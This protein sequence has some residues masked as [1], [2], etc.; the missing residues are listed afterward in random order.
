M[1]PPLSPTI[2]APATPA[3]QGALAVVRLSGPEALRIADACWRGKRLSET[4]SHTV[5]V[6]YLTDA[7]GKEIDQGVATVFKAPTSFTGEDTVEFSLHGSPWI[8]RSVVERLCE[9]G[10]TV[11]SGGE[12]TRRAFINGRL[13][14]AQAE[15][16]ADMIAASSKAAASLAVTQLKGDF[17]RALAGLRD[18]MIDI[19]S[20]LELELDFSEEDVEF[21][22]RRRL[23]ALVEETLGTVERLARS[24]HAGEV[25]K[26]GVPVVIAGAPN[27][28]KS[29]LLNRIVGEEK[30]IVTEIPGTTRDMIEATAEISGVLFRF[31]DTAGIRETADEIERIGI[32]RARQAM[33]RARIL[34]WLD[35]ADTPEQSA[36]CPDDTLPDAL[37]SSCIPI[38]LR[39][40]SDLAPQVFEGDD[41]STLHVSALTGEGIP[42]LLQ[43]LHTIATE[44]YNPDTELIITNR[45]HHDSLCA[46]SEALHRVADG[47]TAGL[48]ADLV[49]QDLREATHHL[50]LITGAVTPSDLLHTIFSRFCI[51]K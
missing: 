31:I 25:F 38:R 12:F 3:G 8:V 17:S 10:A 18:K 23:L 24:F 4:P 6:G 14:L 37:P 33:A 45:R 1:T 30:A 50:G 13:D 42:A 26:T 27:A 36:A 32:E 35:P 16:V 7:A 2:V 49:A 5:R 15:A 39:T 22:D 48:P 44:D 46:A 19:G 41:R 21:A 40:K 11:A 51:G 43:K 20:L 47:L 29:T 28:G 9:A 34:L